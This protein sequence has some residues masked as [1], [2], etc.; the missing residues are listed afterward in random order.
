MTVQVFRQKGGGAA[1]ARNCA[2]AHARNEIIV[3]TG[4]DIVPTP[5][6]LSGHLEGH[7]RYPEKQQALLGKIEWHPKVRLNPLMRYVTEIEPY[8]FGYGFMKKHEGISHNFFYGSNISMKRAFLEES[9]ERFDER[10]HNATYDDIEFGYRLLKRHAVNIIFEKSILGYHYHRMDL[11]AFYERLFKAGR[12][13]VLFDTIHPG[14]FSKTIAEA[15]ALGKSYQHLPREV[16]RFYRRNNVRAWNRRAPKGERDPHT[17]IENL[18]LREVL[19][20]AF[21]S[22]VQDALRLKKREVGSL[23]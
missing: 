20:L 17:K 3:F 10:F 1:K 21:L 2:L 6:F 14:T 22:G 16:L 8:Q 12:T 18:F 7:N 4:D 9:G 15:T 13:A 5:E 11:P 23:V 19:E